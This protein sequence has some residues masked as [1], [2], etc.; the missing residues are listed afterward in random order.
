MPNNTNIWYLC[1]Y[2]EYPNGVFVVD[3]NTFLKCLSYEDFECLTYIQVP[4]DMLQAVV[5]T[6]YL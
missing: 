1:F 5:E 4:I 2:S 6:V 3:F